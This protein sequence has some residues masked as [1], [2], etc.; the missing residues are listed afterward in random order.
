MVNG[1]LFGASYTVRVHEH[2]DAE[3]AKVT[4]KCVGYP[5]KGVQP[6]EWEFVLKVPKADLSKWPLGTMVR[7]KVANG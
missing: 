1:E 6:A 4:L 5:T 2:V 3:V 7:L